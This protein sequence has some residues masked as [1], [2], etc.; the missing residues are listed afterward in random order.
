MDVFY[1]G[2]QEKTP[3]DDV[4][5]AFGQRLSFHFSKDM[6][7]RESSNTMGKVWCREDILDAWGLRALCQQTG[8]LV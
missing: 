3:M 2:T 1:Q 5:R 4:T 8:G 7:S 6:D